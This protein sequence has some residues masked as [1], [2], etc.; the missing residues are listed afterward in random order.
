M[1]ASPEV[2]RKH[3]TR[4]E[5]RANLLRWIIDLETT[6]AK[7][8]NQFLR[9]KDN[10]FCCLGRACVVLDVPFTF[11]PR[12]DCYEIP[13]SAF[14][15]SDSLIDAGLQSRVG[16]EEDD[17]EHCWEMNDNQNKSFVE[18]AAWLRENVLPRFADVSAAPHTEG[19]DT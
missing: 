19:D 2:S 3:P 6:N 7:Q 18:I 8:A 10:R 5:I 15:V 1:K 17:A 13:H 11:S 9:T 12:L 4:A 14:I 16:L